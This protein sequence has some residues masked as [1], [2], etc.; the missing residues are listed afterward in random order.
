MEI[1]KDE[2]LNLNMKYKETGEK[3]KRRSIIKNNMGLFI[4]IACTLTFSTINII[5]IM[6]FFNI[7]AN[8]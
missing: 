1:A 6:K 3:K 4:L 8:F 7:L 2:Y 5:L